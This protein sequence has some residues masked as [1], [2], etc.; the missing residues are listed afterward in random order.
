MPE[1]TTNQKLEREVAEI[2]HDMKEVL[3]ILSG[4]PK[5][6]GDQGITGRILVSETRLDTI[7]DWKL[8]KADYVV[9]DHF[10]LR[11]RVKSL[12]DLNIKNGV[13][14]K[15]TAYI[16]GAVAGMALTKILSLIFS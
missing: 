4:N 7:E 13:F 14:N 6:V 16:I 12:E 11:N 3:S 2:K 1:D 10:D 9:E 8:K 5:V 15:W